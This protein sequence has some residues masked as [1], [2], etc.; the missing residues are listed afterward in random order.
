V[1]LALLIAGSLQPARP[2]GFHFIHR[3]IHWLAFAG[4]S[5]LLFLLSRTRTQETLRAIAI[6]LLGFCLEF[7]Q[8]LIYRNPVEW[9]DVRDD[10]LAILLAFVLYRLTG[11]WKPRPLPRPR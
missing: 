6:L 9:R 10:A 3:E 7:A 8:H 11:S 5:L 1:W 2:G 4:A